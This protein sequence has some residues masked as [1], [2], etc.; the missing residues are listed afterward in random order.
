MDRDRLTPV[1]LALETAKTPP[2]VPLTIASVVSCPL[3]ALAS[4]G[5]TN[6]TI[7][8]RADAIRLIV[9]CITTNGLTD[10]GIAVLRPG[11]CC[12][13][14]PPRFLSLVPIVALVKLCE[15]KTLSNVPL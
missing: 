5:A 9:V 8:R 3:I 6:T 11:P 7:A 10:A 14:I 2:V 12:S 1:S 15:R 4:T 13:S